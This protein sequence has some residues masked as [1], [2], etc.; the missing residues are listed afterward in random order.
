MSGD[1]LSLGYSTPLHV[2]HE[3]IVPDLRL[4]RHYD[5][6][7]ER[8][9]ATPRSAVLRS[10]RPGGTTSSQAAGVARGA[11]HVAFA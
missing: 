3:R 10:L 9:Q 7:G 5:G 11:T 8:I 4:P 6:K 2:A 1:H